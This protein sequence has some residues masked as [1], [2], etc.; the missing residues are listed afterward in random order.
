MK[1]FKAIGML[2]FLSFMIMP[3]MNG[4]VSTIDECAFPELEEVIAAPNGC[5]ASYGIVNLGSACHGEYLLDFGNGS[6]GHIQIISE[7]WNFDDGTGN[8]SNTWGTTISHSYSNYG[9]YNVTVALLYRVVSTGQYHL[10]Q[11]TLSVNCC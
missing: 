5:I 8:Q 9:V 2:L 11:E 3:T 1:I 6:C 10:L 7:T 4:E